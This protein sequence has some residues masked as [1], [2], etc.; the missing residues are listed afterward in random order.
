[1]K[2]T[3]EKL[4]QTATKLF[5][6]H[7]IDGVSTR[8]LA[9]LSGVNLCSIN[10]YFGSKQNLYDVILDNVIEKI[11]NFASSKQ[12]PLQK[13]N[14]SPQEEL[15]AFISN[16]VNFLCSDKISGEQLELLIKEII[17][18]TNIYNKLYQ[19]VIEPMHRRITAIIMEITGLDERNAILQTHC[20]MG[21]VVMFK[22][23]KNALLKRLDV[24]H[25]SPE[26]IREIKNQIIQNCHIL[27]KG[28]TK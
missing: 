24:K 11:S 16:M 5:A 15:D 26:L 22:V 21:Q 8:D 13:Q 28:V 9:K 19:T 20:L 6:K 25:Y 27:V 23:H 18:P 12:I 1:M 3:R 7:G 14:L 10:Y 4:L 17:Q 2:D